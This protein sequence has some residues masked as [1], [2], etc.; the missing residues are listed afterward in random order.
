MV[1]VSRRDELINKDFEYF[2]ITI[3][4]ATG[5]EVID[6]RNDT[7]A[8]IDETVIQ[9]NQLDALARKGT[10]YHPVYLTKRELLDLADYIRNN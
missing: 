7:V 9:I 3:N 4:P 5:V 10:D 2:N 1:K 6:L 8:I